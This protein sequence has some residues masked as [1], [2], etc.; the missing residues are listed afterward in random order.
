MFAATT[1]CTCKLEIVADGLLTTH[2]AIAE[3]KFRP[4]DCQRFLLSEE[5]F[6]ID[7][8]YGDTDNTSPLDRLGSLIKSTDSK[9]DSLSF[10][11]ALARKW[12]MR[13]CYDSH[14]ENVLLHSVTPTADRLR[15]VFLIDPEPKT[16]KLDKYETRTL[17]AP[18]LDSSGEIKLHICLDKNAYEKYTLVWKNGRLESLT[19]TDNYSNK[20][21]EYIPDYISGVDTPRPLSPDELYCKVTVCNG[22]RKPWLIL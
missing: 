15:F 8:P 3:G 17:E 9:F 2:K 13:L 1:K 12:G 20:K 10:G 14:T 11:S 21:Y 4:Y 19:R 18:F 16:S 7:L 5:D 22:S 6:K